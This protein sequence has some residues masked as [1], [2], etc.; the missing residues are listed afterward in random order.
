MR[1]TK[2]E[3][4]YHRL[5]L[6]ATTPSPTCLPSDGRELE[7]APDSMLSIRPS[8]SKEMTFNL[9]STIVGF[10]RL[11]AAFVQWEVI[12]AKTSEGNDIQHTE[13]RIMT[14]AP[15]AQ[16]GGDYSYSDVH[17]IFTLP[18]TFASLLASRRGDL[19]AP[20]TIV[21][22]ERQVPQIS[23]VH[24]IEPLASTARLSRHNTR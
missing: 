19:F 7:D 21:T 24:T 23:F 6:S 10:V 22:R 3:N 13:Q 1:E 2:Q 12:L 17:A 4:A 5:Q 18:Q 20:H 9:P 16:A 15:D 14:P 11:E 8:S